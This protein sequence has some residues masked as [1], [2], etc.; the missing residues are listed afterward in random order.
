MDTE[1]NM[2][3]MGRFLL[4]VAATG[5]AVGLVALPASAQEDDGTVS[6]GEITFTPV[7]ACAVAAGAPAEALGWQ[8]SGTE[9][10][11]V[12]DWSW[13]VQAR[14]NIYEY[15]AQYRAY[16]DEY[17]R[18]GDSEAAARHDAIAQEHEDRAD[19]LTQGAYTWSTSRASRCAAHVRCY[20]TEQHFRDVQTGTI[21]RVPAG[22]YNPTSVDGNFGFSPVD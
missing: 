10:I 9:S 8:H 17:R 6:V 14:A 15:A 2:R 12:D 7:A 3:L 18:L 5:A 4:C 1:A 21:G 16:A 11:F 19:T 13:R 20:A 22:C